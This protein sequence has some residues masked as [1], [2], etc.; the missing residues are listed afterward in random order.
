MKKYHYSTRHKG[1]TNKK[2]E[3]F[4]TNEA[5][6]IRDFLT[7]KDDEKTNKKMENEKNA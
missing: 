7:D 2:K 5:T 4:E 3:Q 6:Y 1:N